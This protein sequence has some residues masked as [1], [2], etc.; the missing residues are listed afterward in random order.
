MPDWR[1]LVQRRLSGLALDFTEKEE[2]HTELAAHLEE[3]YEALCTEGLPEQ[4][5]VQK[6]LAQ[7]GDWK[8]LQRKI[9]SVKRRRQPM[10]KRVHQLWIPGLLAMA[11]STAFLMTV[12][13]LGFQPRM[14]SWKEADIVFN[15][16]WLLLLPF[17]G[18]VGTYISSRAG[19]TRGTVLL[20]SVFP[21]I[22]LTAAFLL[23]FPISWIIERIMGSQGDFRN[24]AA[25][26]L[27]DGIGWILVP[28]AALLAGGL[29]T[30]ALFG[31]RSSSRET[32][33]G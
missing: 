13:R 18:A 20:A 10:H 17:I 25:V 28:G 29:F 22:A 14:V 31:R 1:K 5:A 27:E 12:Q 6:T 11:L 9:F 23:M 7:A 3:S 2:I 33:I 30:H 4:D 26:L 16:P 15:V 32:A 24:V 8:D 19:G 21:V